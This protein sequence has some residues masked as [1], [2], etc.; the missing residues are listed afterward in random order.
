MSDEYC[1]V[2]YRI[3]GDKAVFDDWW[4]TIHP[5]FLSDHQP[6]SVVAVSVGDLI[7]KLDQLMELRP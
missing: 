2:V 6:V 4:K 3:R 1:T 7:E 5:L